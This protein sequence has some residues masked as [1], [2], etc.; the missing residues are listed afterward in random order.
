MDPEIAALA[1]TAGTTL[2]TMLTTDAWNSV[3]D[4]LVSLWQRA[5]PDRAPAI[6]GELDV[7]RD[8]L[9]GAQAVGDREAEA[10]VRAEW[11]GRI[12]RLI[13]AHPELIEELRAMVAELAP[14]DAAPPT[15]TQR[16]T[17]SGRARVYQSGRDMRINGTE[18]A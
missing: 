18:G 4:G 6:A 5:Q 3:R 12:R 15:V 9:L 16:A 11:Q 17:A 13:A 8:E 7:T 14:D 2:V 1:S 10:E